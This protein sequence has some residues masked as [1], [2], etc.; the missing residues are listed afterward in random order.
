MRPGPLSPATE[1]ALAGMARAALL[2][3]TLDDPETPAI[4]RRIA[5]EFPRDR[6]APAQSLAASGLVLAEIELRPGVVG[7]WVTKQPRNNR[8]LILLGRL[9]R[10]V[11]RLALRATQRL[12]AFLATPFV[13]VRIPGDGRGAPRARRLPPARPDTV[14]PGNGPRFPR[15]RAA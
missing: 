12:L 13:L 1:A 2:D 11:D 5:R 3:G 4:L 9:E 7:L 14:C 6:P 8:R 15:R 10:A